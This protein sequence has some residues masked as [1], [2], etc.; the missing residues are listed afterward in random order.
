MSWAGA[1]REFGGSWAKA[2]WVVGGTQLSLA[3]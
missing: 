1:G 2:E 3:W